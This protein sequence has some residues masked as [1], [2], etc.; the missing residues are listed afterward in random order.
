MPRMKPRLNRHVR[1]T[2][3]IH[4][5]LMGTS[6][7]DGSRSVAET[8][9]KW[10]EYNQ[11]LYSGKGDGGPTCKTPAKGSKKGCMKGK[12][13]PQ[14][15]EFEYKG[16][17]QRTRGKWIGEIREPNR[18]SRL[19]LGTFS[20]AQEA[21]LAYDEVARAMYGLCA[22]L[23]FPHISDYTSVKESLKES[24][25]AASVYHKA[26]ES[27]SPT[28]KMKQEPMDEPTKISYLGGGEIQDVRP[29]ETHDVGQVAEDANKDQMELS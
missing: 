8:L 18:G 28:S 2:E 14:N 6:R 4:E 15:S 29:E 13:G 16:V 21:A 20:T 12:G 22:C 1:I 25:L 17:R 10:K 26:Y 9:E 7:G 3:R 23:N 19:W 27:A 11:H 5:M 24:S